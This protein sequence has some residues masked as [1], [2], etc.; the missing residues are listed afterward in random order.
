MEGEC[1]TAGLKSSK[2]RNNSAQLF[3]RVDTTPQD[4]L[5]QLVDKNVAVNR[6]DVKELSLNQI[7]I[8]VAEAEE[9]IKQ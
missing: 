9:W 4:I 7:F 3:L 1:C 8:K 6:F 5:R 2:V